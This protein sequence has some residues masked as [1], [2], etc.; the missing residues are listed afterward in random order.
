MKR[1]KVSIKSLQVSSFI[2][3]I[4]GIR[5][6]VIGRATDPYT[7]EVSQGIGEGDCGTEDVG[8]EESVHNCGTTITQ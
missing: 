2:T 4:Q 5:G 1:N 6:G 3:G 8:C 7:H